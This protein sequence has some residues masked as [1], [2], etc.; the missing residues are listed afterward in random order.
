MKCPKCNREMG[1]DDRDSDYM[2]YNNLPVLT[3]RTTWWLCDHCG[4]SAIQE[5]S[6]CYS[7]VNGKEL[8]LDEYM[9]DEDYE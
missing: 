9:E 7:D 1:I 6:I 8:E 3:K 4:C 2:S 5:S